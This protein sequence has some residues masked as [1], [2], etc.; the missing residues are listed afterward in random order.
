M[1][2][3]CMVGSLESQFLKMQ[4]LIKGAKTCLD[5]G[6]F[7]GMSAIAMA[8]GIPDDGKVITLEFDEEIARAAQSAFDQSNVGNKIEMFVGPASEEMGKLK[9]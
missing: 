9:Q 8:E 1:F 3:P 4:C 5:V 2:S 7:T 6:T